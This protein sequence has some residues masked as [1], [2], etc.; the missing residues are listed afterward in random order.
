MASQWRDL[1]LEARLSLLSVINHF[2]ALT[3]GSSLLVHSLMFQ[4]GD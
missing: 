1:L 2:A 3:T 4:V